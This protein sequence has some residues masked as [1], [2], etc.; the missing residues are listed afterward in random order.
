MKIRRKL[1]KPSRSGQ[2]LYIIGYS[3]EA[4]WFSDL[5]SWFD[6]EYG[7]PLV[8]KNEESNAA[9]VAK[10]A[11]MSHGPW[12]AWLQMSVPLPD[13]EEWKQRLAWRHGRVSTIVGVTLTPRLAI[14][15]VLH[16]ARLAR[17]LTLLT[18]GTAYDV[19]TQAY[20]NPSDWQDRP[21]GEF[22]AKDHIAV[23][24]AEA[25]VADREWF[26]TRGLA[27]FGLEDLETFRPVGLP[28]REV[29]ETLLDIAEE[30]VRKG[31]LP[32]VGLTLPIDALGLS[33]RVVRHRTATPG[34]APLVLRE[35]VWPA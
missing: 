35:I 23:F 13:A 5:R 34:E 9:D 18:D 3:S 15:S 8:S 31:H 17:G 14:D 32:H 27:K 28:A 10:A 33:A 16:A 21:L 30:I 7:G 12:S 22:R 11:L 1:P 19:I 2:P 26:Y 6:L 29:M 4:S 25:A 20:L 24:Q